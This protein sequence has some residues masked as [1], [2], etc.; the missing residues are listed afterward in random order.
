MSLCQRIALTIFP[1][2]VICKEPAELVDDAVQVVLSSRSDHCIFRGSSDAPRA[3]RCLSLVTIKPSQPVGALVIAAEIVSAV[4]PE[5]DSQVNNLPSL[6]QQA[7]KSSPQLSRLH[8]SKTVCKPDC[9]L[10]SP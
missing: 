4:P 10:A 7:T 8:L 3:T 2:V 9:D 5:F 1:L 6:L